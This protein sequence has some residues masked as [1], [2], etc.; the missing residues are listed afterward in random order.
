MDLDQC[1]SQSS[2]LLSDEDQDENRLHPSDEL[3]MG[4]LVD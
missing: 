1:S 4:E 2:R 3:Q